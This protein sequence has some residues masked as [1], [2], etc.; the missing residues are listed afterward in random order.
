MPCKTF[1]VLLGLV[2]VLLVLVGLPAFLVRMESTTETCQC[3]DNSDLF[4]ASITSD[5]LVRALVLSVVSE[6]KYEAQVTAAFKGKLSVNGSLSV[7]LPDA[8]GPCGVGKLEAGLEYVLAGTLLPDGWLE[9]DRCG[10]HTRWE[11]LD[12][13]TR[14]F[15]DS[16]FNWYTGTCAAGAVSLCKADPC[17]SAAPCS[18][19]G[20]VCVP[21]PCMSCS[22]P[23]NQATFWRGKQR[24]CYANSN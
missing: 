8:R 23:G 9:V 7:T 18:V 14:H 4:S 24:V 10:N 11:R 15:V 20:A 13:V 12:N 2:A 21:N 17:K 19:P 16:M 3:L 1:S 22:P 5:T 6:T